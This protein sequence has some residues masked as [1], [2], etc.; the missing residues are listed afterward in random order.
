MLEE[1]RYRYTYAREFEEV[2]QSGQEGRSVEGKI[3]WKKSINIG[4]RGIDS[5]LLECRRRLRMSFSLV[6]PRK[7]AP[8]INYDKPRSHIRQLRREDFRKSFPLDELH[9]LFP[10]HCIIVSKCIPGLLVAETV[11]RQILTTE[12]FLFARTTVRY[13]MCM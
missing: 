1:Y 8:Y 5:L 11:H 3:C 6:I 7:I 12:A 13:H 2:D 10:R 9:F 4:K